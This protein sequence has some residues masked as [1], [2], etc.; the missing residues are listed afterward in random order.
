M[1]KKVAK[2]AVVGV[3]LYAVFATSV[4]ELDPQ[5]PSDTKWE[6]REVFNKKQ[7]A[8]LLLDS[9]KQ[10]IVDTMGTPDI[11]EA[12]TTPKGNLEV[13]FYRTQ[14]RKSDGETTRDECTPLLFKNNKLVAW[15]EIAYTQYQKF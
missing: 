4:I 7:I 1:D 13:L 15:G 10:Q 9:P 11:T 5:D 14:H 12:K 8:T 6:D 2:I 3:V